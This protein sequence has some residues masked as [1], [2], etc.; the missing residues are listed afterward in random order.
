MGERSCK[1]AKHGKVLILSV[2]WEQALLL[3]NV[4][5]L[6]PWMYSI[7]NGSKT[8]SMDLLSFKC[9]LENTRWIRRPSIILPFFSRFLAN[10]KNHFSPLQRLTFLR[11]SWSH[12]QN[13]NLSKNMTQFYPLSQFARALHNSN[14]KS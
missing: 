14:L 12:G 10:S 1:R 13:R 7:V 9:L 8:S 2:I 11:S 6:F 5:L 4:T 3:W